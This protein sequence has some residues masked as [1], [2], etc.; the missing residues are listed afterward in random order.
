MTL[1]VALAVFNEES[2]I[3]RCLDSVYQLAGEIVIVDGHSSDNTLKILKKYLKI[4]V[5]STTNK[6]NFHINKQMA[7]DACRGDWILQLDADEVVPPALAR[8]ISQTIIKTKYHGF[9]LKRKNYFLGRFLTKGGVY[10]DWTIRLYRRGLGRLPCANVH[11]QAIVAGQ[12]GYLKKDLLH[13]SDPSFRRYLTRFHRYTNLLANDVKLDQTTFKILHYLLFK[14]IYWFYLSYFRHLGFFDSWQ[15]FIF[16]L[17][18]S[19]RFPVAYF[20]YVKNRN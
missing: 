20:K 6:A 3:E 17:F 9:W 5:I 4:K 2:N 15:G 12:V 11:E 13:Y 19:L 8:E 14:P 7:I 16:A 10:P 18:S 1:S